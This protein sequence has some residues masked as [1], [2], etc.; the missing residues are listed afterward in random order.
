[1]KSEKTQVKSQ[2]Y[3]CLRE[4]KHDK[5]VALFASPSYC[6]ILHSYHETRVGTPAQFPPTA[7]E[8]WIPFNGKITISN[9]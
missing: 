1:M 2:E 7:Q 6:I 3:P 5:D 9:S 4:N 8:D